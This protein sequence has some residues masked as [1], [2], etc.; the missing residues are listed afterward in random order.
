MS[1]ITFDEHGNS[2]PYGLVSLS[3]SEC[4]SIFVDDFPTSSTRASNWSGY[5]R[6]TKELKKIAIRSVTQWLDGSFT[7]NKLNPGDID[8]VSIISHLDF[9]PKI[10]E[11]D[12][13]RSDGYPKSIFNIDGYVIIDFPTTH[14][15]YD[16]MI[17]Q[18]EYWEKFFSTDRNNNPKSILEVTV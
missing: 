5:I 2:K 11:F 4:K 10:K 9:Q 12:M 8:L 14:P 13:N 6:F 16:R 3:I 15:Y 18:K 7:T 17:A 1:K